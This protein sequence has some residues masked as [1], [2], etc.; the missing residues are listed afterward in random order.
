MHWFKPYKWIIQVVT[1]HET[2]NK[3]WKKCKSKEDDLCTC[4]LQ[5]D[6]EHA[7]KICGRSYNIRHIYTELMR[8]GNVEVRSWIRRR[9]KYEVL[10]DRVKEMLEIK[11]KSRHSRKTQK[12]RRRRGV[13][14]KKRTEMR[15]KEERKE[16]RHQNEKEKVGKKIWSKDQNKNQCTK[17]C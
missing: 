13:R 8:Y 3:F 7:I 2:L 4:R 17:L 6:N 9:D 14:K 1:G 5:D 12:W 11:Q 10:T 16:R 15:Q